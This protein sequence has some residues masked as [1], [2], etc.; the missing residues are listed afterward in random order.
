MAS[1][2]ERLTSGVNSIS[3]SV[4]NSGDTAR[5]NDEMHQNKRESEKL[6]MQLGIVLKEANTDG[7][8]IP[9]ADEISAKIDALIERNAELEKELQAVKG[10]RYCVKCKTELAQDSLFCPECGTRNEIVNEVSEPEVVGDEK[11][12]AEIA[13]IQEASPAESEKPETPEPEKQEAPKVRRVVAVRKVP[14]A[15]EAS[16]PAEP[17]IAEPEIPEPVIDELEKLKPA[18]ETK[19]A[20]DS[21]EKR[22]HSC[23]NVIPSDSVFCPECGTRLN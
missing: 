19:E 13:E 16:A 18:E 3:N 15:V 14:E 21:A 12:T 20:E 10:R 22:C 1:F 5:I 6:Y 2:M 9:E 8:G 7:F 4:K 23:G 17:V 11:G